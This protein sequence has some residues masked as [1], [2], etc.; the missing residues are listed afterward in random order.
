VDAPD[1]TQPAAVIAKLTV[2]ALAPSFKIIFIE[3]LTLGSEFPFWPGEDRPVSTQ[4]K[5]YTMLSPN[6]NRGIWGKFLGAQPGCLRGF[7]DGR[8]IEA[9]RQGRA[10]LQGVRVSQ[11]HITAPGK[12]AL[13]LS[14]T[15]GEYSGLANTPLSPPTQI[16]RGR[17]R[18][19]VERV[20]ES[21]HL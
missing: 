3:L 17:P 2:S 12:I 6:L 19:F 13:D 21:D 8:L 20:D 14:T 7:G 11:R 16:H 1:F 9:N 10:A 5:V 15:L 4:A 18:S